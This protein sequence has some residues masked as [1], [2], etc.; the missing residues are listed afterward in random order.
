MIMGLEKIGMPKMADSA[1]M[2]VSEASR[3]IGGNSTCQLESAGSL[4]LR[5]KVR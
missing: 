5:R 3:G 1:G 4:T 2:K